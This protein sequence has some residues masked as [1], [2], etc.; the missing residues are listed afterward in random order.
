MKENIN[1]RKTLKFTLNVPVPAK[2]AVTVDASCVSRALW[3]GLNPRQKSK[4][5][6]SSV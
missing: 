3:S 1:K 6:F 4:V 5:K 2:T